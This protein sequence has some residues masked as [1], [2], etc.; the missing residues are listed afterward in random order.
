MTTLV[1]NW[2][3]YITKTTS[4][5]DFI[6]MWNTIFP[7]ASEESLYEAK[8]VL[9]WSMNS[10]NYD[11]IRCIVGL[12]GKS[13]L[14]GKYP[15]PSITPLKHSFAVRQT[16]HRDLPLFEL[17]VELGAPVKE[18]CPEL[19]KDA[20]EHPIPYTAP[21][22]TA[23]IL[24]HGGILPDDEYKGKAEFEKVKHTLIEAKKILREKNTMK[25]KISTVLM[26]QEH[27]GMSS[28][29][30]LPKDIMTHMVATIHKN[31]I[32]SVTYLPGEMIVCSKKHEYK[33]EFPDGILPFKTRECPVCTVKKEDV[34][35]H[36]S[37]ERLAV[38]NISLFRK[39]LDLGDKWKINN[40]KWEFPM[41]KHA[42]TTDPENLSDNETLFILK[43]R[44]SRHQLDG[45][46]VRFIELQKQ[47]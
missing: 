25:S 16:Q 37:W 1:P 35:T 28:L 41:L 23:I 47:L 21:Q 17:L 14:S 38:N 30:V 15:I 31:D 29:S 2:Y 3:Q 43:D 27:D 12:C 8:Q 33:N 34:K 26:G 20:L 18:E 44:I 39:A 45:A 7:Q 42:L 5:N 19:L 32:E 6:K 4:P 13:I 24:E 40:M 9:R 22:I 46:D 10:E 11:M 36:N